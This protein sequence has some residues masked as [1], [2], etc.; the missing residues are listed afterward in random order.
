VLTENKWVTASDWTFIASPQIELS[1]KT[2]G[3]IGFGRI[4]Q[5]TGELARAFGMRVI[6]N[7]TSRSQ[8][9]PYP[10]EW[11]S[12][13]E[14]FEQSDVISLH[15]PLTASNKEFVNGNLLRRMKKSAFL[16]NTARG[17]LINEADLADALTKGTLAGAGIDVVSREPLLAENPLLGAPNLILTPHIAWATLEARTRL[18]KQTAENLRAFIAGNPINV[19][20]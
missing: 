8:N 12:V 18:M 15:C 14:V 7:S 1:G 10:F 11:R 3:V 20:N 9:A 2:F 13:E 6:A 19:V 5:R 17:G 4:G 16:I